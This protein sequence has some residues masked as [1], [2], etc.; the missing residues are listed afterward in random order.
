M[1]DRRFPPLVVALLTLGALGCG[2]SGFPED[3]LESDADPVTDGTPES[4]G[5]DSAVDSASDGPSIDVP[6]S[7]TSVLSDSIVIGFDTGIDTGVIGSDTG[8]IDGPEFDTVPPFDTIPPDDTSVFDTADDTIIF[9]D[10]DIDSGTDTTVIDTGVTDTGIVFDTA[11]DTV[12][13]VPLDVPGDSGITCGASTCNAATQDC[14]A[15]FTGLTCV[16]K[17]TCAGGGTL[18]CSDSTSCPKGQV[19]CFGAGGGAPSAKCAS[20]CGGIQLCKTSLECK[21]PQ[22]CQPVFGGFRICR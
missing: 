15:S 18:S 9:I 19:C 22:T 1:G 6:I 16:A 17:G 13:D 21:F 10:T 5:G 20:T 2:R 14:C 3:F 4:G 8:L 12:I 11:F 7:D